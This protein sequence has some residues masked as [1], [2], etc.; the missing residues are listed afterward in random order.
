MRHQ[1][2]PQC[3]NRFSEKILR[4][5]SVGK[6]PQGFSSMGNQQS[7]EAQ[8]CLPYVGEMRNIFVA[9]MGRESM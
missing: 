3:V 9:G 4:V 6:I 5:D 7:L 1:N 8:E 2:F